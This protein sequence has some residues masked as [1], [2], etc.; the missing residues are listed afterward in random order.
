MTIF[1]IGDTHFGHQE[2]NE[3]IHHDGSPLRRFDT[4]Y[5]ADMCMCELWNAT[6]GVKDVVYHV[7]DVAFSR[8]GLSMFKLLN[9]KKYLVRGN[10]DHFHVR[11]YQEAGFHDVLGV[12]QMKG[13][14]IT[15]VPMHEACVMEERVKL[16]IHG[17][18]HRNVVMETH[19]S[20]HPDWRKDE[21]GPHPKYFN[22]SVE[23]IAYAPISLDEII[24]IKG[25]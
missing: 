17:H 2:I 24:K 22:V 13:Y 9:G 10:H 4:Y 23:Q 19:G 3:F 7:G 6:V 5:E 15:H 12:K 8:F 20:G 11:D 1:F 21:L 14:W 25:L 16:N 18:L